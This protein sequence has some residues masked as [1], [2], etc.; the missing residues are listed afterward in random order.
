M[1]W[2]QR[3]PRNPMA[4]VV[5][6]RGSEEA[7][8]MIVSRW[9]AGHCRGP[10]AALTAPSWTLQGEAVHANGAANLAAT[11]APKGLVLVWT[12]AMAMYGVSK[13]SS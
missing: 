5:F 10:A 11:T 4:P 12:M 3:Q 9:A 1:T 7:Q 2:P 8:L 13:D 6:Q